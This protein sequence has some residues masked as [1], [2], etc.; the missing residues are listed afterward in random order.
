MTDAPREP[1]SKMTL[2]E[3]RELRKYFTAEAAKVND[4]IVGVDKLIT[5]AEKAEH[6][7]AR[8][9][10]LKV[11][12]PD[13][14]KTA[15]DG[16][17]FIFLI[18][19]TKEAGHGPESLL[20]ASTAAAHQFNATL[21]SAGVRGT[22]VSTRF[23]G[24]KVMGNEMDLNSKF[25]AK[26]YNT[27]GQKDAHHFLPVAK[28][29]MNASTPDNA[30]GH[31][32]HYIISGDGLLK[33]DPATLIPILEAAAAL[34]PKATFDFVVCTNSS[35]TAMERL[36]SDWNAHGIKANLVK[37]FAPSQMGDAVNKII[38]KHLKPA[39]AAPVAAP[40]TPKATV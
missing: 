11:Y 33:E 35:M 32:A 8:E 39:K 3:L 27:N 9:A 29:L 12:A 40:P 30:S 6:D 21:A 24:G 34:N 36:V 2:P 1:S 38:Q 10:A 7:A 18:N 19:N 14:D 22:T 4:K 15:L 31:A 5:T 13:G 37:V 23:W 25:G 28:T 26:A 20:G 17:D 16:H